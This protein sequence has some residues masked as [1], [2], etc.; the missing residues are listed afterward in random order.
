M[1]QRNRNQSQ[2]DD[3]DLDW[4]GIEDEATLEWLKRHVEYQF[5]TPAQW[6]DV[7]PRL[8]GEARMLLMMLVYAIE[9]Y[10]ELWANGRPSRKV[11]RWRKLWRW[12]HGYPARVTFSAILGATGVR[13]EAVMKCLRGIERAA[14]FRN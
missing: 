6:R 8:S 1:G 10:A 5:M 2:L 9:E 7:A 4:L 14:Q 13:R 3:H 12:F 11:G